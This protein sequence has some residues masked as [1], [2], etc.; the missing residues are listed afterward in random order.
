MQDFNVYCIFAFLNSIVHHKVFIAKNIRTF[1]FP[2]LLIISIKWTFGLKLKL[3]FHLTLFQWK[4]ITRDSHHWCLAINMELLIF[5]EQRP[6]FDNWSNMPSVHVLRK[7]NCISANQLD[8]YWN[9]F[10]IPGWCLVIIPTGTWPMFGCD[11]NIT[12]YVTYYW[13]IFTIFSL[14]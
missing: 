12:Y 10:P 4:K 6:C 11:Y 2:A 7:V 14:F 9:L 5:G 8:S 3:V 13:Y 1:V